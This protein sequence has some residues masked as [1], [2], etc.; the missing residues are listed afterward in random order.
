MNV[1]QSEEKIPTKYFENFFF[2]LMNI[3]V[4]EETMQN[5]RKHRDI[6]LL[7]TE[8]RRS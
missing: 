5:V 3:A 8:V 1:T 6:K 4:F 2:K 7:I